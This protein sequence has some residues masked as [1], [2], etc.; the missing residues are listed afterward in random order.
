MT[1]EGPSAEMRAED[2]A[3]GTTTWGWT[4]ERRQ[5]RRLKGSSQICRREVEKAFPE[6]LWGKSHKQGQG[7]RK[8]KSENPQMSPTN[9]K[10]RSE[11]T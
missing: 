4:Q 7:H 1:Q 11:E 2:R 5:Q 3:P 10:G 9:D 8:A 6:T